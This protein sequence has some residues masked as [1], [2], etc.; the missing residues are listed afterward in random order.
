[1]NGIETFQYAIDQPLHIEM[2]KLI[3]MKVNQI[4]QNGIWH[5]FPC[6]LAIGFTKHSIVSLLYFNETL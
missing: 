6:T 5:L 2:R 4:F 1:M 3:C